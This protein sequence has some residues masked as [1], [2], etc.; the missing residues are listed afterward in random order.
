MHDGSVATLEQAL[1]QELYYRGLTSGQPVALTPDE[2]AALLEFLHT[3][4]S[5][6]EAT[7]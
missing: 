5:L 7:R 1:D 6:A 4:S 3:L 2:K